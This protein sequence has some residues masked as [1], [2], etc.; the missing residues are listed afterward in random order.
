MGGPGICHPAL[1]SQ[2]PAARATRPPWAGEVVQAGLGRRAAEP[3]RIAQERCYFEAWP[4]ATSSAVQYP[5]SISFDW[6]SAL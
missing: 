3:G 2:C 6:M 5:E 1:N 4:L